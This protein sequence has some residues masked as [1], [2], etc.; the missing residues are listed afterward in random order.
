[1]DM[2]TRTCARMCWAHRDPRSTL[3]G[4]PQKPSTLFFEPRSLIR[5]ELTNEASLTSQQ[6][7]ESHLFLSPNCFRQVRGIELGSLC[8]HG[9]HFT[10][11]AISPSALCVQPSHSNTSLPWGCHR[12]LP[13][14]LQAECVL[15][16]LREMQLLEKQS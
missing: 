1:M 11:Q 2:C 12:G 5:L 14:M 16:A 13:A 3:N 15:A 8:L 4:I 10:K 6:A 7:P 9:E